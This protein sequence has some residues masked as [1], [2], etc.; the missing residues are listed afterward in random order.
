MSTGVKKS[1]LAFA[2]RTL[3]GVTESLGLC[4]YFRLKVE[5][6]KPVAGDF[7]YSLEL[8]V[9][10]CDG[11]RWFTSM[12]SKGTRKRI[13]QMFD[14]ALREMRGFDASCFQDATVQG[15]RCV[16]DDELY[17]N[18]LYRITVKFCIEGEDWS[19]LAELSDG[20]VNEYFDMAVIKG[21]M[22]GGR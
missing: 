16:H 6:R 22:Q 3:V 5:D 20:Q 9:D 12:P 13:R 7:L 1:N 8:T 21:Y 4:N 11:S 15:T 10:F 19:G 17:W 14:N 18:E 2:F